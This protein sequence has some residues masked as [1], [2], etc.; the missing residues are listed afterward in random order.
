MSRQGA[1]CLC[2]QTASP[3][4]LTSRGHLRLSTQVCLA[5]MNHADIMAFLT[6]FGTIEHLVYWFQTTISG[7][8]AHHRSWAI[9]PRIAYRGSQRTY[10]I[11]LEERLY[12]CVMHCAPAACSSSFLALHDACVD[13]QRGRIEYAMVG[14]ASAL[15]RPATTVAFNQLQ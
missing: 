15:L 13:L 4:A 12:L 7:T 14:G 5:C 6:S 8:K 11:Q 1:R 3:S 9:A 2:L 10:F